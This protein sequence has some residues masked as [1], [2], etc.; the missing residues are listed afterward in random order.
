MWRAFADVLID[1]DGK[2]ASP[3]KHTEF[4]TRVQKPYPIFKTKIAKID[5]YL[6]AKTAKTIPFGAAHTY[7]GHKPHKG[8]P[9][10]P[11]T[12]ARN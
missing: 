2:V 5:T 11:G 9:P 7:I 8:V 6:M 4:K 10:P 12:E 3:N 1:N